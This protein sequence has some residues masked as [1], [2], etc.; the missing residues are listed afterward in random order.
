MT[1][2][3]FAAEALAVVRRFPGVER[4]YLDPEAFAIR[5]ARPGD[6]GEPVWFFLDNVFRE[7]SAGSRIDR[8]RRIEAVLGPMVDPT[9][10]PTWPTVRHLLRPVLRGS[11][12]ALS[13]TLDRDTRLWRPAMPYLSEYVVIDQ[14]TSMAYVSRDIVADWGVEPREV[15]A[16]ARSNVVEAA[17]AATMGESGRAVLRFVDDGDGYF[18]SWLLVD[19]FLAG[20]ADRVGSPPVAFVPDVNT[21][22]VM[23]DDPDG[24]ARVQAMVEQEYV[25]APRGLSPVAYTVDRSGAVVEYRASEP[26]ELADRVHRAR[27]RLAADEYGAQTQ[28]LRARFERADEDVFV[29]EPMVVERANGSM[30]SLAVWPAD[31]HAL[32]PEADFVGFV[33]PSGPARVP[34]PLV[35]AETG[36]VAEPGLAPP[37]YRVTDLPPAPVMSRLLDEAVSL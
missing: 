27:L 8:E 7:T 19:G 5:Y 28:A 24:V 15:F 37:R 4:A 30:F 29:G 14:P 33:T 13:A 2:Q 25:E 12:F 32:L 31:C 11:T 6:T 17:A 1:R 10:M 23:S 36:L 16:A 9:P 21:L 26:G 3:R 20:M 34:W 22:I 18:T 35:R